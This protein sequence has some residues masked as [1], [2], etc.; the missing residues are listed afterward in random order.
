MRRAQLSSVAT[1]TSSNIAPKPRS[2]TSI[3]IT[4]FEMPDQISLSTSG[5]RSA[6]AFNSLSPAEESE[7]GA[8]SETPR[9]QS[10]LGTQRGSA[11]DHDGNISRKSFPNLPS[12]SSLEAE[13]ANTS[14]RG[15]R[16]EENETTAP[17]NPIRRL[18][19]AV[20]N[21]LS[22]DLTAGILALSG[23]ICAVL[24]GIW[25]IL[26]A[27]KQLDLGKWSF[28]KSYPN[29]TVGNLFYDSRI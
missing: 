13:Q 29:D 22:L 27:Q 2:C 14:F 17:R 4:N 12:T 16:P 28:C 21:K 9:S 3:E 15:T 8:A 24:V 25:G 20:K 19:K 23:L 6:A 18:G 26:L 10:P 7:S 5:E 11:L 1:R